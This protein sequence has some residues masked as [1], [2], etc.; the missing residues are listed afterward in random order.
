MGKSIPKEPVIEVVS[1]LGTVIKQSSEIIQTESC[2]RVKVSKA[3][4]RER[5][6]LIYT[7]VGTDLGVGG[8]EVHPVRGGACVP[9]GEDSSE[10]RIVL[11][12]VVEHGTSRDVLKGGI[13]V[14]GNQNTSWVSLGRVLNGLDHGIGTLR[15]PSTILKGASALPPPTLSWQP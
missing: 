10:V 11:L 15:A 2:D 5:P 1:E 13:E 9:A 14:K 6:T 8:L 4:R 7:A 12:N 3:T